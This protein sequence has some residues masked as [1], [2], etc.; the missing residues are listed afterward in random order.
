MSAS[1]SLLD[2]LKA[3]NNHFCP[4][5]SST[6]LR[7]L[8]LRLAT[9]TTC[10]VCSPSESYVSLSLRQSA[11]GPTCGRDRR[12]EVPAAEAAVGLVWCPVGDV[13]SRTGDSKLFIE[14]TQ[15]LYIY[16]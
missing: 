7:P 6:A 9:S 8:T 5:M 13:T 3:G 15:V 2:F 11:C 14:G 10:T 12:G 1:S 4:T 16:I